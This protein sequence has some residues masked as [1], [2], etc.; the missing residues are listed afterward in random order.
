VKWLKPEVFLNVLSFSEVAG[1]GVSGV[2]KGQEILLGNEKFVSSARLLQSDSSSVHLEIDG[3]YKGYFKINQQWRPGL[4]DILLRLS[5]QNRLHLVSGDTETDKSSLKKFF[6]E[7]D[8]MFFRQS[9]QDKLDY[10]KRLQ[11][12]G[13]T[14][15]MCGDGLND[16]GALKQSDLGIAVTDDINNFSPGCDGIL[17]GE[18]L[19][20]LPKFISQAKDAMKTIRL[21]FI[22]AS[23][24][25]IVGVFFAV[26]G[27]LSPLTAAILMPISTI[28]ILSFTTLS[29]KYFAHKNKLK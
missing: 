20:L 19:T 27:T 7:T 23:C 16:A 5:R 17:H 26:Q 18:S 28:T 10:I 8:Q 15:M 14:V 3:E 29:T 25:N 4:K 24:Y 13:N 22:I 6:P 1:R 9:P 11:Q 12:C 21:S 2:V